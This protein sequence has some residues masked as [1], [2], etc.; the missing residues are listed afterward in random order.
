MSFKDNCDYTKFA[1]QSLPNNKYLCGN[2]CLSWNE[3]CGCGGY[4]PPA[5][6]GQTIERSLGWDD[7]GGEYCCSTAS[8]PCVMIEGGWG[9]YCYVGN[10]LSKK[11]S[12]PC[13]GTGYCYNDYLT[14]EYLGRY[15]RYTI[16]KFDLSSEI[17]T[18]SIGRKYTYIFLNLM[19]FF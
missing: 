14:S 11:S 17:L 15:T 7:E 2:V 10:V 6:S 5:G 1:N 3:S 8:P 19:L 4:S 12:V 18:S 9:A 13:S 16:E